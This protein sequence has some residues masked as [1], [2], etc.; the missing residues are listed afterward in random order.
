MP[1]KDSEFISE[2]VNG[3]TGLAAYYAQSRNWYNE[4]FLAPIAQRNLFVISAVLAVFTGLISLV[5]CVAILPI[6][7]RTSVSVSVPQIDETAAQSIRLEKEGMTADQTILEFFVTE[8]V[9][10]RESYSFYSYYKNRAFVQAHSDPITF[11][12]FDAIFNAQNPKSPAAI[13]GERGERLVHITNYQLNTDVD[14]PIATVYFDVEFTGKQKLPKTSWTAS[15][16]FYYDSLVV[17]EFNDPETGEL[18]LRTQD[19]VFKVVKYVV[20][21]NSND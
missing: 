11:K 7:E 3:D 1:D 8:Y 17:E 4:M 16:S 20:S 6:T 18:S 13:L 21:N 9:K 12:A 19:P 14:P 10:R 2:N 15:F 5:S